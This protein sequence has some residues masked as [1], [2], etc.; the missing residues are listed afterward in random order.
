MKTKKC[1]ILTFH[2]AINFGAVLQAY[3]LTTTINKLGAYC[4][5]ID[6]RCPFIEDLYEGSFSFT[7][8]KLK[9]LASI[10]IKNGVL[11]KNREG[12]NR[13]IERHI[14][15]SQNVYYSPEELSATTST[16]DLFIT[17]SDQVWNCYSAGFDKSYF[18]DFV[19]DSHKKNSYAASFGISC[20]PEKLE[21]EYI[22]LL[23]DFKNISV[24]EKQGSQ[25]IKTLLNREA[26]ISVDPTL[27]LSMSEWSQLT[28]NL[29]KE[30]NRYLLVYLLVEAKDMLNLARDLAKQKKLEIVY[31][32]DRVY[33]RK[34]MKNYRKVTPEEWLNLFLNAECI[35]TNSFHGIA[36][37]INFHKEFYASRLPNSAKVNSRIENIMELFELSNILIKGSSSIDNDRRI[38]YSKVDNILNDERKK[39]ERYLKRIIEG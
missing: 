9:R 6:Y 36:F 15:K 23:S 22:N 20:I 16:Y 34:G 7:Y 21:S 4:E 2:R 28:T 3:A 30:P 5:V 27:L 13:F 8:I 38:D 31:I 29:K 19:S 11:K 17:G 32:S 1:G 33:I 35:V 12:F 24:R 10:L 25:I 37:S 39:A 14:V 18:L 26:E